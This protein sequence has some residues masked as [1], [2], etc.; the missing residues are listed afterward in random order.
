[1]PHFF[2]VILSAAEP[3]ADLLPV[4][5]ALLAQTFDDFECIIASRSSAL[6]KLAARDERLALLEPALDGAEADRADPAALYNRALARAEGRYLC[7]LDERTIPAPEWL[8][9]LHD[10]A[11]RTGADLVACGYTEARG[12]KKPDRQV[13]RPAVSLN[14]PEAFA[15][16]LTELLGAGLGDMLWNKAY[17]RGVV[18]GRGLSFPAGN[19]MPSG[20]G[21][22]FDAAFYAGVHHFCFVDQ[23]L[24]HRAAPVRRYKPD[25][26]EAASAFYQA[27][28]ALY[29]SYGRLAGRNES[30]LSY[31]YLMDVVSCIDAL[32]ARDCPLS[33]HKRRRRVREMLRDERVRRAI[34]SCEEKAILPQLLLSVMRTRLIFPNRLLS[35]LICSRP[36]ARWLPALRHKRLGA[37]L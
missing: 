13:T 31:L 25:A 23:C 28:C 24:L 18:T 10:A 33:W 7:F 34:F 37:G 3:E 15:G 14:S 35:R 19:G 8:G 22:L 1:M 32:G 4:A 29:E 30:Q 9:E 11:G 20:A 21:R 5:E 6:G 17:R 12:G 36:A 26:F 27:I 2:T 16:I